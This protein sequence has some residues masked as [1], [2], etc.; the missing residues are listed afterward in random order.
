MFFTE[1]TYEQAL[2]ALFQEL[3]F[4]YKYGPDIEREYSNP[5]LD[6]VLQESLQRIN[7]TL[8]ASAIDDAIRKLQ[9]IEGSSLYECNF[10]FTQM[11]Q[12]GIEVTFS[13]ADAN[14]GMARENMSYYGRENEH[15]EMMQGQ[16]TK[17]VKLIDFEHLEKNDFLVV[18]QYTVQ[19][20]DTK[21]PDIVVFVN[22]LPLVVIEL[23]SPSREET[24]ASEAYL[25]LRNY[26]KFIPS[27]FTYN[28]FN[29]MSDMALTMMCGMT[30]STVITLVFTP[31][32]YSVIDN[33]T[34]RFG[35]AQKKKQLPP[36]A[37]V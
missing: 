14:I 32:Y 9:Q 25:Q 23:K 21:R 26:Q 24:D 4:R 37:A 29:V 19:E 3:G 20:L 11:M 28:A 12:Y 22:G 31:V 30:I 6:D 36:E 17:I 34:I 27:L 5:L 13:E 16:R 2:I 33:M 35:N 10:K 18:N 15:A 8:P 7:P 1:D